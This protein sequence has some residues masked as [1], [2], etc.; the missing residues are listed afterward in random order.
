MKTSARFERTISNILIRISDENLVELHYPKE[1]EIDLDIARQ[2]DAVISE[3]INGEDFNLLINFENSYGSMPQDV[4]HFFANEAPSIPQIRY[5]V[6]VLNSLAIRM[7]VKFYLRVSRP[8]YPTK[9]FP[10]YE[11]GKKWLS[12]N[13]IIKEKQA[14]VLKETI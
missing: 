6:I 7:L 4:Q 10:T 11:S 5:S 14:E 2:I 3:V 9:I 12:Q 1:I 8:L 13:S